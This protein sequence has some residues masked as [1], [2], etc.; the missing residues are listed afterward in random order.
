MATRCG[1]WSSIRGSDWQIASAEPDHPPGGAGT[2]ITLLPRGP[3]IGQTRARCR[4]RRGLWCG[5]STKIRRQPPLTRLDRAKSISRY[6]PPKDTAGLGRPTV[7]GASRLPAPPA[8]TMP[9]TRSPATAHRRSRHAHRGNAAGQAGQ[10][11]R[12]SRPAIPHVAV[13]PGLLIPCRQADCSRSGWPRRLSRSLVSASSWR[14]RARLRSACPYAMADSPDQ[15]KR[16]SEL[17]ATRIGGIAPLNEPGDPMPV[18]AAGVDFGPQPRDAESPELCHAPVVRRTTRHA[19]RHHGHWSPVSS[20]L[21]CLPCRSLA[22]GRVKRRRPVRVISRDV[23]LSR[24]AARPNG[25]A[26]RD[27]RQ[28]HATSIVLFRR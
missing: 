10:Q 14:M 5:M 12:S 25:S 7:S 19:G 17:C 22:S 13:L 3:L 24:Q 16:V 18:D 20:V 8:S 26:A 2:G 4:V 23:S 9:S 28:R 21:P 6:R 15:G 11:P 1:C 27:R